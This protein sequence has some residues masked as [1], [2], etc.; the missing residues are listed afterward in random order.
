MERLLGGISA[1]LPQ[2]GLYEL[3]F[4]GKK[5]IQLYAV[6]LAVQGFVSSWNKALE[7]WD[8]GDLFQVT[9]YQ[10]TSQDDL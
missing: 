5:L 3:F 9:S 8:R 1:Q 7:A 10:Q 6:A 4:A 2:P